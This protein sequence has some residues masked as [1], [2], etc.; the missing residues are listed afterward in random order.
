ML[1]SRHSPLTCP[2]PPQPYP[3]RNR[4]LPPGV[5]TS[6]WVPIA[7]HDP[8]PGMPACQWR[9][10]PSSLPSSKVFYLGHHTAISL[11]VSSLPSVTLSLQTTPTPSAQLLTTTQSALAAHAFLTHMTHPPHV[12][13]HT[14]AHALLHCTSFPEARHTLLHHMGNNPL[15]SIFSTETSSASLCTYIHSSQY[16]LCPLPPHPDPP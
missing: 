6:S 7:T 14:L 8:Q 10:L 15:I 5:R 2:H 4:P 3:P 1:P 9:A 11:H 13:K 16:F 12:P